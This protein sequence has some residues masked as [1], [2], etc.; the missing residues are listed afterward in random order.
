MNTQR[1]GARPKVRTSDG[2]ARGRVGPGRGPGPARGADSDVYPYKGWA[3]TWQNRKKREKM[4][5]DYANGKIYGIRCRTKG[6]AIVYIGSTTQA[7]CER[8]SQHRKAAKAG[9]TMKLYTLMNEVG[10][11]NFHIELINVF[12]CASKEELLREEG[13]HIRA[14]RPECNSV[15]AG[16]TKKE[17]YND[18]REAVAARNKAWREANRDA[19]AANQKAWRIANLDAV[20]A[21]DKE[22]YDAHREAILAQKKE[23]YDAHREAKLARAKEYNDARREAKALY[24]QKRAERKRAERAGHERAQLQPN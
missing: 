24:D 18:N 10:V 4:P 21:R 5:I 8:F 1:H 23:Y 11:Q 16:R 6:D 17:Y 7:L 15:I 19:V 2:P 12:P 3:R 14:M 20:T 13:M 9:D 22:N